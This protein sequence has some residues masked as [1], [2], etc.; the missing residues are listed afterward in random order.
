MLAAPPAAE[1]VAVRAAKPAAAAGPDLDLK[2]LSFSAGLPA[3]FVLRGKPTLYDDKGLFD[4]IDGA[5][6]IF[7]ERHF[8]RLAAAEL[9]TTDG[10]ELVCDIYDMQSAD[11][12]ASIFAKERPASA[13]PLAV[14]DEGHHGRMSAGFRRGRYYVKLTAF[15]AVGDKA[16]SELAP[17]VAA[18]MP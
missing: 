9:T 18:K 6:P 13:L 7:I 8:R 15:N 2:L 3:K 4:Y 14:G 10:G 17:L 11:N 16:L 12:A 1:P 5:A